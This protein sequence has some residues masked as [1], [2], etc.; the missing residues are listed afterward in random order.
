MY[1]KEIRRICTLASPVSL[2]LEGVFGVQYKGFMQEITFIDEAVVH[3]EAGKG[4][5]G[6]VAFRREKFVP[7][8]GPSG[9]GR[10]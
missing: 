1:I 4:G 5:A 8:G 6:C 10:R 3:V 7:L 9:G 2:A